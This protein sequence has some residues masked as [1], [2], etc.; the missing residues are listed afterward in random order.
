MFSLV[1]IMTWDIFHAIMFPVVWIKFR[2]ASFTDDSNQCME[3]NYSYFD[4][5]LLDGFGQD[6]VKQLVTIGLVNGLMLDKQ[7]P[8]TCM[9]C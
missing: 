8:I 1:M 9:H 6:F 3:S 4:K 5:Y 2:Q 7:Q